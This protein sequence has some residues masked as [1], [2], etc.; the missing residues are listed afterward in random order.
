MSCASSLG[1]ILVRPEIEQPH[2]REVPSSS[3]MIKNSSGLTI[4]ESLVVMAVCVILLWI[5]VPV[6]MVRFG[7]KEAGVMVVT[8]GDKAPAYEGAPLNPDAMKPRLE[9]LPKPAVMPESQF[10]PPFPTPPKKKPLE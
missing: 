5:V 2:I 1:R 9:K 3:F 10:L 8:E 4:L 6:C 7:W